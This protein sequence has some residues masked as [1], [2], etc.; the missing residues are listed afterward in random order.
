MPANR[1]REASG[2]RGSVQPGSQPQVGLDGLMA[3]AGE[4]NNGFLVALANNLRRPSPQSII[5]AL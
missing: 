4:T 3:S 5:A 1:G 2:F